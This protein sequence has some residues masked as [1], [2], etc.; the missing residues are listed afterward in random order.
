MAIENKPQAKSET[1]RNWAWE[2]T[3]SRLQAFTLIELLVVIAIISILAAMLLP[4]L[5]GSKVRAQSLQCRN[6]LH[7]LVLSWMLYAGDFNDKLVLN[8]SVGNIAMSTNDPAIKNG[9]WV[10]GVIGTDYGNFVSNTDP[11]LVKAGALFPY[12]KSLPIYKCPADLKI[13][14]QGNQSGPTTRSMSMNAWLNPTPVWS[15]LCRP[16]YKLASITR[17]GPSDL[18]VF[19]D[20][21]PVSIND[22]YFISFPGLTAWSDMPACY[23]SH[24]CG[25]AFADGHAETKK[26][27]DPSVLNLGPRGSPALQTPPDDLNW[28]AVRSTVSVK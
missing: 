20:E 8:G 4:A 22:G 21:S 6:N 10:H 15:I 27:H 1:S 19:I 16:Y 25:L 7:Q 18:W 3:R 2:I 12:N 26:W 9:N 28:L 23:H 5:A 14:K 24:A 11:E 13:F 17:P